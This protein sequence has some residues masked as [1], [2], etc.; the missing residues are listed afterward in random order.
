M[1]EIQDWV[2]AVLSSMGLL[3]SLNGFV[4]AMEKGT[5]VTSALVTEEPVYIQLYVVSILTL[6]QLSASLLPIAVC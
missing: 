6:V 4:W 3:S 2:P 5:G 1:L